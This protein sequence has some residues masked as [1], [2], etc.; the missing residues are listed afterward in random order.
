MWGRRVRGH[1][2]GVAV[3][4]GAMRWADSCGGDDGDGLLLRMMKELYLPSRPSPSLLSFLFPLPLPPPSHLVY[5]HLLPL[6]PSSLIAFLPPFPI[7]P[8]LPLLYLLVSSESFTSEIYGYRNVGFV[9][10][11][12][13]NT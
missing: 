10:F 7:P 5:T 12:E 4:P 11:R 8:H 13:D 9:V 3:M 6:T 2:T 1:G